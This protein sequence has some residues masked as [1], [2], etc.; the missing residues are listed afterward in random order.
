MPRSLFL[1]PV[2]LF[3]SISTLCAQEINNIEQ[4]AKIPQLLELQT[5]MV[6][7][8]ELGER[9]KIQL[10]YGETLDEARSVRRKFLSQFQGYP[11]QIQFETPNYKVWIGDFRSRLEADR[12]FKKIKE[13]F[14]SAFI[15][16]PN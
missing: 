1:V 14:A 6:K 11:A 8:N 15:F 13:E 9:Y 5:N 16:Q 3:F 10:F 4:D 7:N 2:F 12:A